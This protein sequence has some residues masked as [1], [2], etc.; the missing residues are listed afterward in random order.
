MALSSQGEGGGAAEPVTVKGNVATVQPGE[1][2][3]AVGQWVNDPTYGRQFVAREITT[4]EPSS[5]DGIR[6]YLGS[7]LIDGIGP[8]YRRAAGGKVWRGAYST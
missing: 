8:K 3:E 6:R 7:G 1:R 5:L 2:L 4:T